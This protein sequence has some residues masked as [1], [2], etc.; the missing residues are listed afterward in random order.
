MVKKKEESLSD[1]SSSDEFPHS[2]KNAAM[3][4]ASPVK[5][6]TKKAPERKTESSSK[7][8]DSEDE[9]KSVV[10]KSTTQ[11]AFPVAPQNNSSDESRLFSS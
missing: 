3:A 4:K 6:L 8:S 2:E 10:S 1:Y 5:S 11:K 7:D 9:A